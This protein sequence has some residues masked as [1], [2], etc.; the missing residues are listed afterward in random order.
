MLRLLLS[1]GVGLWV[2]LSVAAGRGEETRQDLPKF[3]TARKLVRMYFQKQAGYQQGDLITREQAEQVFGYL[4]KIRWDVRDQNE[5]LEA[6][7]AEK[8]FL[9]RTLRTKH[10][11]PFMREIAKLPQGY[12]RLDRLA[13]L[14]QGKRMVSDLA[15]DKDGYKMIEYLAD[16]QGG[17]Y[18]GRQLSNAPRGRDFNQPTGRIY[19]EEE[20]VRRLKESYDEAEKGTK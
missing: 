15:R 6:T 10:G 12:D 7:F 3:E 14:P 17:E 9:P 13:K 16:T 20:F 1:L 19:T 18:L 2:A 8:D 4:Q 5:I 11:T